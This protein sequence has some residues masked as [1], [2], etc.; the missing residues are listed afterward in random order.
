MYFILHFGTAPK[1]LVA[2][3]VHFISLG[4]YKRA[5]LNFKITH[6][7]DKKE[8]YRFLEIS[9]ISSQLGSR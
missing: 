9:G 8:H 1:I 7:K 5:L 3:S 6:E 2:G 4:C